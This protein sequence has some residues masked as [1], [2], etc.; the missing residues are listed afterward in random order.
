MAPFNPAVYYN[1]NPLLDLDIEMAFKIN[2]PQTDLDCFRLR[3]EN[4][5]DESVKGIIERLDNIDKHL[6]NILGMSNVE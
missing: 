2:A 5:L 1:N 4:I 6:D 3:I